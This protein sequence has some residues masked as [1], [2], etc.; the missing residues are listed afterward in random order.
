MKLDLDSRPPG[1]VIHAYGPGFVVINGTR[2]TQPLIVAADRL[3]TDWPPRSIADVC[4]AHLALLIDFEP[5]VVLLGSGRR[6]VRP[7]TPALLPLL[8]RG[9]GVEVMDTGAACRSYSVLHAEQR[10]VVAALLMIAD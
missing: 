4:A 8:Q 2:V 7:E 10:R 5:E 9:I 3:S 6:L 1:N